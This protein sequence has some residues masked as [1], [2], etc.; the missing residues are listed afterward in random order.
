ME[1]SVSNPL[2]QEIGSFLDCMAEEIREVRRYLHSPEF[3]IDED[4]LLIGARIL[5]QLAIHLSKS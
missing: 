5:A 3:D 1:A 2:P 4:A